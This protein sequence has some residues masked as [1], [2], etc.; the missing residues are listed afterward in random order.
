MAPQDWKAPAV[1]DA[2]KPE[3]KKKIRAYLQSLGYLDISKS[4]DGGFSKAED[5]AAI[6]KFQ[7]F[8]GL[9]DVTGSYNEKTR[10]AMTE[11][12]CGIPENNVLASFNT[13]PPKWNKRAIFWKLKNES[14]HLGY[15]DAK[16]QIEEAFAE[17]Q[18]YFRYPQIKESEDEEEDI[19]IEFTQTHHGDGYPFDGPGNVLAH[20]FFPL[21]SSGVLAGDMH[22]DEA[23]KWTTTFLRQ[24]ALHE[25]GHSLGLSHSSD[26]NSVMWPWFNGKSK[27]ERDDIARIQAL[28][29]D[30]TL[31]STRNIRHNAW[32]NSV[33]HI[34]RI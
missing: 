1:A 31:G 13:G 23:E 5:Y 19:S 9:K 15:E 18:K 2:D 3:E 33:T 6:R 20:A 11:K 21:P 12:R 29:P 32:S 24:V 25:L 17:W 16:N 26:P 7:H 8:Y 34:A 10:Q 22:F 14:Q 30:H 28:Y 27:L 4:P